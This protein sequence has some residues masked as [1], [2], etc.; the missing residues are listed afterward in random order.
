L[1][2]Y[3]ETKRKNLVISYD[4]TVKTKDIW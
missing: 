1:F 2:L 4:L 3:D